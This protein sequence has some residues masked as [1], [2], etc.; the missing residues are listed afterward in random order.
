MGGFVYRQDRDEEP[1]SSKGKDQG[2][3]ASWYDEPQEPPPEYSE[4][5]T[6]PR[7]VEKEKKE[8]GSNCK[9]QYEQLKYFDVRFIINDSESM[10]TCLN[11]GRRLWDEVSSPFLSH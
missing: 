3:S 5:E 7:V 11:D 8:W 1:E 2:S 10:N 6:Q 9:K 4:K